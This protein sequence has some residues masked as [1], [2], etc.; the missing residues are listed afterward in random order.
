MRSFVFLV[1]MVHAFLGASVNA[2][3]PVVRTAYGAVEGF[4]SEA[5]GAQVFL[6]V[7]YA[8]PPTGA[9]RFAAPQPPSAWSGVLN[10]TRFGLTCPQPAKDPS[11]GP[12][13][14]DCLKLNIFTPAKASANTSYA[15]LIYWY[16]QLIFSAPIWHS[17]SWSNTHHKKV[18]WGFHIR[19]GKPARV[20]G[21]SPGHKRRYRCRAG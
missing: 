13:G 10:A 14:E 16:L 6:G 7:P 21:R 2:T 20:S 11:L 19:F 1:L 17:F 15:V 12:Q 5:T 8:T 18:W 3:G 9:L 4:V